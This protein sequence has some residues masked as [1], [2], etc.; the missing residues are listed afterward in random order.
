MKRHIVRLSSRADTMFLAHIDFLSQA[1]PSAAQRL[2]ADL[3]KNKKTIA[4]NP[5][6]FPFADELD[7]PGIPPETYRKCTFGGRYKA[8]FRVDGN[9]VYIDAIIDCRQENAEIF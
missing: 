6:L 3:R 8:L 2:I 7:A 4:G 5:F 9:D 1:S